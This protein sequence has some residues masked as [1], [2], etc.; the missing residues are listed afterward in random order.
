M[1]V[2]HHYPPIE[3]IIHFYICLSQIPDKL[4]LFLYAN[5]S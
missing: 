1:M 4:E 2:V 3:F 5:A